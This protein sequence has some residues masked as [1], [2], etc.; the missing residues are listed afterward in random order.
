PGDCAARRRDPRRAAV[1]AS[2]RGSW[3][4]EASYQWM[5][6]QLGS[7]QARSAVGNREGTTGRLCTMNIRVPRADRWRDRWISGVIP[8]IGRTERRVPALEVRRITADA[9]PTV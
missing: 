9:A 5:V 1:A 8:G 2:D 3:P 6:A 7:C 4:L